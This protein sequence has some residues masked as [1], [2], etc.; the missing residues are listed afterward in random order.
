MSVPTPLPR[1]ILHVD[2]DAFFAAVEERENP[3][4][5]GKPVVIGSDPRNGEGRGVVSTANYEA[6]K[7]GIH[8]AMPISLAWRRCSHAV[9]LRPRIR[10][11]AEASRDVFEVFARFTDAIEPLGLDEAFLDVTAS[12]RL[13]GPGPEVARQLKQAVSETTGLT[14]SVGCAASKFVA[15]VAS[16]LEKPD[17]LVI[18]PAGSEADFLAPLPVRRLWGAGPKTLAVLRG[19]GCLTIGDVA[20]LE[21]EV[22]RRRFGDALGGRFARL[23]RGE[24]TRPVRTGRRRKSLGKEITFGHDVRDRAD[25]DRTLL[26]LCEDVATACRRKDIAGS[27][28]AIKLRFTGF[29][30]VT[31]QRAVATP[32]C[33]VERIWPVARALFRKADRPGVPIR[34]IG[35]TLSGFDSAGEPQLGMFDEPGVRTDQRVAEAVDRLRERFGRKSVQRAL[36]LDEGERGSLRR[37]G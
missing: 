36:L 22:L 14:A 21:P 13:F 33:T 7:F 27:T 20:S 30:T 1:A 34:L 18:V 24:D 6:R 35:V 5:R 11:Y 9:Y 2:M 3:A 16:D 4:L 37:K 17:G 29:E 12:R 25:V 10:L 8:S 26:G 31:R 32:V 28:V 23:S 19:L 15:K